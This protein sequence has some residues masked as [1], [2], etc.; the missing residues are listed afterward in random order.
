MRVNL[1]MIKGHIQP[2]SA[3]P[4]TDQKFEPTITIFYPEFKN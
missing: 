4:Y 2:L 3:T 1:F